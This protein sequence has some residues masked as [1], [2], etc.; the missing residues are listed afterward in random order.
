MRKIIV[1]LCI[2][3]AFILTQCSADPD[4]SIRVRNSYSETFTDVKI[5]ST[6]LGSLEAGANSKYKSVDEG[7]FT[8]SVTTAGGLIYS[9]GGSVSGKGKH[10]WTITI[11][12]FASAGISMKED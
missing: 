9:N 8:I 10:K 6:S 7:D 5:N 3:G 2:L 11:T 1:S 12:S 4:H